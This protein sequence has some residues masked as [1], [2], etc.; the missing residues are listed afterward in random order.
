[1]FRGNIS[2]KKLTVDCGILKLF[3][4]GD[5]IMDNRRFTIED[6]LLPGVSVNVPPRLNKTSQ[7]TESECATTHRIAC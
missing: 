5:S 7:L 6:V 1:M 3:E 4:S 2:D